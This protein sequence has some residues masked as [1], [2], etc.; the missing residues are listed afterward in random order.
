MDIKVI[1]IW[2]CE[3]KECFEYR[4]K[5]LIEEILQDSNQV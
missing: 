3:I 5:A 1:V 4:M 2:E